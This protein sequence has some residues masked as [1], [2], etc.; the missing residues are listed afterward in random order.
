MRDQVQADFME[1]NYVCTQKEC[2]D[3]WGL[4][5]GIMSMIGWDAHM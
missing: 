3:V 4:M 1:C 5:L 2:G